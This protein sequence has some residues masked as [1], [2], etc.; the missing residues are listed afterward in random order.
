MRGFSAG[1]FDS[2]LDQLSSNP[3][4]FWVS[5]L[6]IGL[7]VL[8]LVWFVGTVM[9]FPSA[10]PQTAAEPPQIL[11]GGFMEEDDSYSP[12]DGSEPLAPPEPAPFSPDASRPSSFHAAPRLTPPSVSTISPAPRTVQRPPARETATPEPH[13]SHSGGRRLAPNGDGD[14]FSQTGPRGRSLTLTTG[15]RYSATLNLSG[16][17]TIAGNAYIASNLTS[18]GFAN[19]S[20][21]GSGGTRSVMAT[22][23]GATVTHALDRHLS[24]VRDLSA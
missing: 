2:K 11:A 3:I 15:H 4:H 19:V 14:D 16:I 1:W 10:P 17:E 21:T 23:T 20:V 12:S 24:N 13:D 5:L 9:L 18:A 8:G 6:V 22:W 7:V